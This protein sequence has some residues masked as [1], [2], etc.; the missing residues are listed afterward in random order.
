MVILGLKTKI[1]DV[2]NDSHTV[3]YS[4]TIKF[5]NFNQHLSKKDKKGKDAQFPYKNPPFNTARTGRWLHHYA[6]RKFFTIDESS[7]VYTLLSVKRQE[8]S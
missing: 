1:T 4:W 3:L 2:K 7:A 5:V 8:F 6:A